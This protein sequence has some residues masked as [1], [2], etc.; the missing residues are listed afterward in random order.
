M[1]SVP[2]IRPVDRQAKEIPEVNEHAART[3]NGIGST[4]Y[5]ETALES[6][7]EAHHAPRC[8]ASGPEHDGQSGSGGDERTGGNERLVAPGTI[9]CQNSANGAIGSFAGSLTFAA[10][11]VTNPVLAALGK[12][13]TVIVGSVGSA[14][15]GEL[16]AWTQK[17]IRCL[18][19]TLSTI[20]AEFHEENH[21]MV[22]GKRY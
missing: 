1:A 6:T 14:V 9:R 16:G 12:C 7:W 8:E 17:E 21:A 2:I 19:E 4:G 10:L 11:M 22:P 18:P 13:A 15:F 5:A 20:K 3:S